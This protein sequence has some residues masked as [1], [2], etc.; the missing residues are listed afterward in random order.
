VN[1]KVDLSKRE[2]QLL[3]GVLD[4]EVKEMARADPYGMGMID[5]DREADLEELRELLGKFE[6]ALIEAG[7]KPE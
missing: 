5:P 1:V 2:L 6:V 4:T 7:A 3:V